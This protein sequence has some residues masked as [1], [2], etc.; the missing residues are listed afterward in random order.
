[1]QLPESFYIALCGTILLLGV[2][3]WFWTQTQYIQRKVNLLENVVYDMKTLV[4]NL[5]GHSVQSAGPEN[6]GSNPHL[7]MEEREREQEQEQEPVSSKPYAPP[8]E[9][10]AG[11]LEEERNNSEHEFTAFVGS[12]DLGN[13]VTVAQN[14]DLSPGGL[15]APSEHLEQDMSSIDKSLE[16]PLQTMTTKDLRRM[17]E[18]NGVP[19]AAELK[20]KDLI[21]VLRDKVSTIIKNSEK[22]QNIMS[23][24]EISAPLSE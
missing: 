23:F 20:K 1:M 14:D 6:M 10:I 4:S 7:E 11:D 3:Y 12:T 16:S 8:P 19:G 15:A 5:P 24:D 9:S 18:A 21:K 13:Q 17:A 22:P 2:I